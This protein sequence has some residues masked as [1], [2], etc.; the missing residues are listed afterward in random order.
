MWARVKGRTENDLQKLGFY[1]VFNFRPGYLHPTAGM[2]NTLSYYGYL[3]WLYPVFRFLFPNMVS[4]LREL[5]LAM[6]NAATTGYEKPILEV[7]DI[8]ILS[9]K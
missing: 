2:K 3:S 1:A 7:R 6:I 8:V 5:G 4:T 9:K